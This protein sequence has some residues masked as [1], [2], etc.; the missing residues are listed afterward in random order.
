M[1]AGVSQSSV[2]QTPK[3]VVWRAGRSELWRYRS[4]H[5]GVSPPLLIVY[6]LFNRSYILDLRPGNSVVERLLDAGFDV[7]LLDW[8]V[9]DE[10]DSANRL[11][12]YVDAAIPAAITQ[13]CRR[14]GTGKVNLLGYCFGGVLTL[15]HAAH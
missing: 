8:G 5:I 7:Y 1:V 13:V 11:E 3:E 10:R 9:P 2:G 6:S 12:D 14:A 15:L 4:D